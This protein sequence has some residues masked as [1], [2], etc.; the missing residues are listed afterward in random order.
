MAHCTCI[1]QSSSLIV[2]QRAGIVLVAPAL[3]ENEWYKVT[4][5]QNLCYKSALRGIP[6]YKLRLYSPLAPTLD[7]AIIIRETKIDTVV[8]HREFTDKYNN[9]REREYNPVKQ[10]MPEPH[11]DPR[12]TE[13]LE[14]NDVKVIEWSGKVSSKPLNLMV[15]GES[16]NP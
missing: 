9:K 6:F 10:R 1:T 4:S 2:D 14:N 8:Y 7:D 16:F 15:Q 11:W 5:T 12:A 3:D 13:F